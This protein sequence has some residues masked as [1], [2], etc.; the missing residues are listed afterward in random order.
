[1]DGKENLQF[2]FTALGAAMGLGNAMRFP[3]LCA[4]Y[5]G[6]FII[7]YAFS[8]AAVYPLLYAELTL[9]KR[10]RASFPVAIKSVNRRAAPLGYA[11]CVNSALIAVYYASVIAR[12]A[13][14]A[15]TFGVRV[16]YG[17]PADIPDL[18]PLFAALCWL[19]LGFFLTRSAR[20]RALL[21]RCAVTA[22]VA[23]FALLAARGLIYENSP[24]ALG[25]LAVRGGVLTSPEIWLAALGQALLSLSVA[26]GV[27]PSFAAVMPENLSPAKCALIVVAANFFGGLLAAVALI[28]VAGGCN[29]TCGISAD[30]FTNALTL[31][32]AALEITFKN[33]VTSG[34]FGTVF[35]LSLTLTATVSALSL[36]FP[37]YGS[38]DGS[39]SARVR[40][41]ALCA[42]CGALSLPFVFAPDFVSV[43]DFAACNVVAPVI[44]AAE[45]CVFLFRLLTERRRR[46]KIEVWKSYIKSTKN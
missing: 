41:F 22:Q 45:C 44:A 7:A 12:L 29:L 38:L 20:S 1:M 46:D 31:F 6:G 13:Q 15:C 23:L 35:M 3:G 40:A 10:C 2:T 37:L 43:A 30:G 33:P 25:V 24:S 26:A 16:N 39:G 18:T 14:S 32:P 19:A 4:K 21:A 9:G 11:A 17:C 36:L 28:T 34:I 42:A 27:M 5:G 8:L